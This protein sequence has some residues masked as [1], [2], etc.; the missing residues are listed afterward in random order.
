M[1]GRVL[2]LL[3]SPLLAKAQLDPKPIYRNDT[4]YTTCGYKIYNG[5]VLHFA[6][7]TGSKGKF[8]HVMILNGIAATSLVN[9]SIVVKEMKNV[10]VSPLDPGY[11]DITGLITFK[12]STKAII[13]LQLAYDKAIEDSPNLPTELEVPAVFRNSSRVKLHQDL[14]KLFRL[15]LSGEISKTEYEDRK[16][17]LLQD[18]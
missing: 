3:L 11:A 9:N 4:L 14:N 6:K 10:Q 12:D 13:Q 1:I 8:R 7:G 5:Q 16:N 2:I 18:Q 15:F 17:K